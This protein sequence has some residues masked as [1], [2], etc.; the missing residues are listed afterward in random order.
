MKCRSRI[1]GVPRTIASKNRFRFLFRF[2]VPV[3]R[4]AFEVDDEIQYAN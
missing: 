3:P 1:E 2:Q 4:S